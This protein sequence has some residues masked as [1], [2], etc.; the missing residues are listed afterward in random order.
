QLDE[1]RWR[2]RGS[3][4][5]AHTGRDPVGALIAALF[6]I[7]V[8]VII[9]IGAIISATAVRKSAL[10]GRRATIHSVRAVTV[11][12]AVT[13][14]VRMQAE[15]TTA[16]RFDNVR[17]LGTKVADYRSGICGCDQAKCADQT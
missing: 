9:A 14:A 13:P 3:G 7:I 1:P 11:R 2:R 5:P 6:L 12:H 4:G 17:I 8:A 16:S 15:A 10:V